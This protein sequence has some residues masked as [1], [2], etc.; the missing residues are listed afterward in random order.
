MAGT[1]EV[2]DLEQQ[3]IATPKAETETETED[4]APTASPAAKYVKK[5]TQPEP[6]PETEPGDRSPTASS[7]ADDVKKESDDD[8]DDS[9]EGPW[10]CVVDEVSEE[11]K[12]DEG[13]HYYSR[14]IS[15]P[16]TRR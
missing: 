7:V 6:E 12:I 2:T 15:R 13:N 3:G 4:R 1:V 16:I 9:D 5:E 10:I 14:P 11:K 8:D